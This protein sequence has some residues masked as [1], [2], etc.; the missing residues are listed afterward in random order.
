MVLIRVAGSGG[1]GLE[2]PLSLAL[3]LRLVEIALDPELVPLL[4]DQLR[5]GGDLRHLEGAAEG[6]GEGRQLRRQQATDALMQGSDGGRIERGIRGRLSLGRLSLGGRQPPYHAVRGSV[7]AC[8][9]GPY[10]PG[11]I[12]S[13]SQ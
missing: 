10:P 9:L 12:R 4:G 1:A 2:L 11:P 6:L 3:G 8:C 7:G 13:L 5:D